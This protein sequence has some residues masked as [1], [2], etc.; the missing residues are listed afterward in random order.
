MSRTSIVK[1]AP[2]TQ[3]VI[4]LTAIDRMAETVVDAVDVPAAEGVIVGAAVVAAVPVAAAVIVGVAVLAAED[5]KSFATDLTIDMG[6]EKATTTVVAFF[7]HSDFQLLTK[8]HRVRLFYSDF[9]VK[10]VLEY[11][12]SRSHL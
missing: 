4:V 6:N 11:L 5:T 7:L 3:A 9:I 10:I 2:R 12:A 1:E 8:T